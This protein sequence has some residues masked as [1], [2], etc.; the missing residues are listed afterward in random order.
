MEES[1]QISK[2]S[3]SKYNQFQIDLTN[4]NYMDKK[5]NHFFK[6]EFEEVFSE[7]LLLKKEQFIGQIKNGV[8]LSLEDI[9]S[10]KCLSNEKLINMIENCLKSIEKDYTNISIFLSKAWLHHE[11]FSKRRGNS[12]EILKIFRKH[13]IDTEEPAYHNCDFK[14]NY[15]IVINENDS[16]NKIKYVICTQCK[17]VYFSSFIL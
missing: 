5:L 8:S 2:K 11:K 1:K 17:R 16:S 15:F 13:C 9:Y 14:N 6:S 10:E 7:I 3:D 4:G 12:E